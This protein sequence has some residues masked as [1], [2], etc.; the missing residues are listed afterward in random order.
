MYAEL[1]QQRHP[2]IEH[3]QQQRFHESPGM[4][5]SAPLTPV[6]RSSVMHLTLARKEIPLP[7]GPPAHL[8]TA[9]CGR[10]GR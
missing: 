9:G 4:H 2:K 8:H 7:R 10:R 1:S 6:R 5:C 3:M